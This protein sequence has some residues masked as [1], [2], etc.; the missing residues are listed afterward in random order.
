[1]TTNLS[2]EAC[3]DFDL[4]VFLGELSKMSNPLDEHTKQEIQDTIQAL[5]TT[6]TAQYVKHY[7]LGLVKKA[8]DDLKQ[9][10]EHFELLKRPVCY[11][12]LPSM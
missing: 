8:E 6:F 12:P 3:H 10:P 11:P 5:L 9:E 1:V 2:Y 7:T 4:I